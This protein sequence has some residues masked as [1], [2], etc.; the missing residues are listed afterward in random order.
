MCIQSRDGA[1]LDPHLLPGT[2]RAADRFVRASYYSGLLAKDG[3]APTSLAGLF[4][5]IR[6]VSVPTGIATPGEPNISST[7]WRTVADQKN[8][9]YYFESAHTPNTV[10][11][12]LKKF[13]LSA[14]AYQEAGAHGQRDLFRRGLGSI[15]AGRSVQAALKTCSSEFRIS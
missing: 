15:Q 13:D 7:L 3:D 14:G 11:T 10:G 1:S 5:V 4:S 2:G 8:L 9:I 6:N 12:D